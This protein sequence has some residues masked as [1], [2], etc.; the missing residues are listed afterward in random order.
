MTQQWEYRSWLVDASASYS[1]RSGN[2]WE[3]PDQI[4]KLCNKWGAEG[5]EIISVVVPDHRN[6]STYRVTAKRP[7]GGK[8][9]KNDGRRFR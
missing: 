7:V 3:S 1:T 2:E 6:H 4:E 5:W 9:S 8:N